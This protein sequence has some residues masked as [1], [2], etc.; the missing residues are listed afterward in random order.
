MP[1]NVYRPLLCSAVLASVLGACAVSEPEPVPTAVPVTSAALAG[2]EWVA[3]AI[4]G[5]DEV[6][7]P[8]PKLRWLSTD[9]VSGTGGCNAFG[10]PSAG[11]PDGLRIGPLSPMGKPCMTM[12]GEQEDRFFGALEQT[13]RARL[14]RGQLVLMD[15]SG[16]VLARFLKVN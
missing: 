4:D 16:K 15:A 9:Q 6:L 7:S 5:L 10:A 12:P 2:T 14:D 13:R 3:F 8:K 1:L 11:G